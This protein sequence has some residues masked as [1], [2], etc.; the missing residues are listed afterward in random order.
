MD[1]VRLSR[2][3]RDADRPVDSS[4]EIETDDSG[5]NSNAKGLFTAV[6]G[7]PCTDRSPD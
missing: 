5:V 3:E 1:F 4:P 7:F 2:D 6:S